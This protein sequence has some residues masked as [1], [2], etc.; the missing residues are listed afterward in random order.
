MNNGTYEILQDVGSFGGQEGIRFEIIEVEYGSGY[1]DSALVGHPDGI[2]FFRLGW[3]VLP[4][5]Q[6]G[7]IDPGFGWDLQPKAIY[8]YRFFCRHK[9]AGNKSFY[10]LSHLTDELVLVKFV[11]HEMT[12]EEFTAYLFS[13]QGLTLQQRR[14]RR[15]PGLEE[16]PNPQQ[17]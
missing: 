15:V 2:R 8:L 16:T 9:A 1:D 4:R 11:E 12:F 7:S 3:N 13:V 5:Y 17:I 6:G 10:V 14:E